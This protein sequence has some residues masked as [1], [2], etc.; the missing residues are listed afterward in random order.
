MDLLPFDIAQGT[1]S[2][3][4]GVLTYV[5]VAKFLQAVP[6]SSNDAEADAA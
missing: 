3:V 5:R 6:S 4:A 2:F 1:P